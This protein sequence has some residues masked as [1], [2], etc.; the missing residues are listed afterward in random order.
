MYAKDAPTYPKDIFSMFIVALF[1]LDR[2]WKQPRCLSAKEWIQKMQFIC[3]RNTIQVLKT[4][5]N[6]AGKW[7]ELENIILSETQKYIHCMYS[8]RSRYQP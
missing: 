7:I 6:F 1:I 8:L 3:T 5:R 4:R 2:N